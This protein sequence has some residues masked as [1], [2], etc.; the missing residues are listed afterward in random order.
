[1]P[2]PFEHVAKADD[3]ALRRIGQRVVEVEKI[4]FVSFHEFGGLIVSLGCKVS[5]CL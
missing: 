2:V 1:M 4:S 5:K 3:D